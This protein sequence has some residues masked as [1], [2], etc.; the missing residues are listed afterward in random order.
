MSAHV[1]HA[2][3]T[4]LLFTGGTHVF[5]S[6]SQINRADRDVTKFTCFLEFAYTI[7]RTNLTLQL[8]KATKWV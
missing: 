4:Q 5:K 6:V 1:S 3:D 7:L 8:I 2:C